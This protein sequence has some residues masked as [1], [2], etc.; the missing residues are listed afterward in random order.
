MKVNT[1]KVRSFLK[2]PPKFRSFAVQLLKSTPGKT[3]TAVFKK[4]IHIVINNF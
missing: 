4:Q 1:A 3:D 2:V